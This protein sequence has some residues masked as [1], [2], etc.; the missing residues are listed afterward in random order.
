M[1]VLR[2]INEYRNNRITVNF[3]SKEGEEYDKLADTCAGL[4]R[5]DEQDQAPRKPTTTPLKRLLWVGLGRG[6]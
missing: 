1:A 5:A 2:I 6:D 4:Y 3:S